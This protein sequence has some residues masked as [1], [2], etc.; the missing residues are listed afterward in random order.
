MKLNKTAKIASVSIFLIAIMIS[1]YIFGVGITGRVVDAA[2]LTQQCTAM[3]VGECSGAGGLCVARLSDP[4]N[5]QLGTPTGSDYGYCVCCSGEGLT[6]ECSGEFAVIGKLSSATNA[7]GETATAGNYDTNLCLGVTA[8]TVSCHANQGSCDTG[9]CILKLSGQTNAHGEA[10]D[11]NVD[12]DYLTYLCCEVTEGCGNEGDVC[13]VDGDCCE[14][15]CSFGL[16]GTQYETGHCCFEG[17]FWNNDVGEC[18]PTDPCNPDPCD[19][20]PSQD[21]VAWAQNDACVNPFLGAACCRNVDVYGDGGD[22]Y[23]PYTIYTG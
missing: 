22:Y 19:I 13:S 9:V 17:Y 7:H 18:R 20:D 2:V 12:N 8:G 23:I 5:A 14:G 3:T 10:C 1:V 4:T 6:N 16:Y 15:Y 11:V 21:F